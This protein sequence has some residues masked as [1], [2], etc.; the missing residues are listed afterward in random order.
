MVLPWVRRRSCGVAFS[1]T[2]SLAQTALHRGGELADRPAAPA[3]QHEA[4][5]L[6]AQLSDDGPCGCRQPNSM[7]LVV[8]RA[9][10]AERRHRQTRHLPPAVLEVFAPHATD[11][12]RPLS[13]QQ[14]H[15]QRAR[16]HQSG[17]VEG[18][19]ELRELRIGQHALAAAHRVAVD[20][21]AGVGGDKLLLYRPGEDRRRRRQRLVSHDGCLYAGHHCL[22]VG[23]ADRG[24]LQFAPTRQQVRADQGVG[25]LPALV[26]LLGVQLDVTASQIR[27]GTGTALC[28]FL[29]RRVVASGNLQHRRRRELA[30]FC[31]SERAGVAQVQPAR[32]ALARVDRLPA[33]RPDRRDLERQPMLLA[34]PDQIVFGSGG[35]LAYS[36]FGQS[37]FAGGALR[38]RHG[39]SPA[40]PQLI[41]RAILSLT[42][43]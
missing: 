25:L 19:P 35:K 10:P 43:C 22:D 17:I 16:L 5:G 28:P 21:P 2:S 8:L 30:G 27:E 11:L 12:A 34:V 29:G 39:D 15:L 42:T 36:E 23:A 18:G 24:R 9:R 1:A 33:L 37:L 4:L 40:N 32:P 14:E 3:G 6:I 13:G 31:Q 26:A 41:F 7:V 38:S 20:A